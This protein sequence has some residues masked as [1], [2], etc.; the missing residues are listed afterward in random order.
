MSTEN[1]ELKKRVQIKARQKAKL[2]EYA[3]EQYKSGMKSLD[4]IAREF[5][6]SGAASVSVDKLNFWVRDYEAYL[7]Y[8]DKRMLRWV[9]RCVH[10]FD[11]VDDHR[12]RFI[13][14]T[15]PLAKEDPVEEA[16]EEI[17]TDGKKKRVKRIKILWGAI[18]WEIG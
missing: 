17:R 9:K 7:R 11:N 5:R 4:T 6:E 12:R 18:E 16:L 3:Y 10:Y 15:E 14:I 2:I 8:G 13:G 1:N